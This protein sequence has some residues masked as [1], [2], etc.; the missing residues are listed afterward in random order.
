MIH[1]CFDTL[2]YYL[3]CEN[4]LQANI[5]DCSSL[6]GGWDTFYVFYWDK[7]VDKEDE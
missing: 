7:Q 6:P 2:Y 5:N 3:I 4:F 1:A